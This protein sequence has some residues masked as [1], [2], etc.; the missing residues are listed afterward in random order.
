M[1]GIGACCWVD[2]ITTGRVRPPPPPSGVRQIDR[3]DQ[4]GRVYDAGAVPMA[5]TPSP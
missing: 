3:G 4:P 2:T 1:S 5:P